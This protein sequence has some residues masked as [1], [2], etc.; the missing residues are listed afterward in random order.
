MDHIERNKSDSDIE[1]EEDIDKNRKS[2]NSSPLR[3]TSDNFSE[4]NVIYT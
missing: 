4:K 3:N 2:N 1:I